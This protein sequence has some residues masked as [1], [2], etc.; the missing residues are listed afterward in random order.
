MSSI[1]AYL[2]WLV[3][4]PCS[5]RVIC[6]N[7]SEAFVGSI[8]IQLRV[9]DLHFF[10]TVSVNALATSGTRPPAATAMTTETWF[11]QRSIIIN[12]FK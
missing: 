11:C 10:M 6:R 12:E 5:N 1:Y 2:P 3:S 8:L 7:A 4:W 9:V